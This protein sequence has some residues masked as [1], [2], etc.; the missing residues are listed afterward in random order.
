MNLE[1]LIDAGFRGCIQIA[2]HGRTVF[3]KACGYADL[4][5]RIPN[6]SSTK[7]ATASAGKVFVAAGILQLIEKGKLNFNDTIGDMLD[8]DLKAIDRN[9]TIKELLTHTGLLRRKRYG[10]L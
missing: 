9:I 3:E 2:V 7:F 8:F 10:R 1:A 6:D 5:N 4:P